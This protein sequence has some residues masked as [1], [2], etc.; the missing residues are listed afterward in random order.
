MLILCLT[1]S[2]PL[3]GWPKNLRSQCSWCDLSCLCHHL[4]FS[5]WVNTYK[6]SRCTSDNARDASA[7]SGVTR[8]P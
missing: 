1:N 5:S 2:S 4:S 7:E 6:H 8:I 3:Q